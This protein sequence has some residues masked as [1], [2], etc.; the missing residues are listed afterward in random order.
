[1]TR[2]IA[3]LF[4]RILPGFELLTFNCGLSTALIHNAAE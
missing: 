2:H 4:R 3:F 1:M